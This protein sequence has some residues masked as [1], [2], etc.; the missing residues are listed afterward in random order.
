MGY[1]FSDNAIKWVKENNAR[2]IE[3]GLKLLAGAKI[4]A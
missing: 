1:Y 3:G 2:I 4:N